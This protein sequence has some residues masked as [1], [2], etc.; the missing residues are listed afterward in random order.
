[1]TNEINKYYKDDIK[2]IKKFLNSRPK[3]SGCYCYG[4]G[5]QFGKKIYSL[6]ILSNDIWKWQTLNSNKYESTQYINF[7]YTTGYRF[8]EYV[9]IKENNCIFDYTIMDEDEFVENQINWKYFTYAE[10]F[11]KPFITI[12]SSKKFD[13]YIF[14]NRKNALTTSLLMFNDN[15]KCFFDIMLN[16]YCI[17]GYLT[18]EKITFVKENYDFLK[19]IYKDYDFININN[20]KK[21]YVNT[22]KLKEEVQ[23][24]PDKIRDNIYEYKGSPRISNVGHFLENKIID[25]KDKISDMRYLVNGFFRTFDYSCRESKTKILKRGR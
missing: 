11:Q 21:I 24:L 5:E 23:F 7:L 15:E 17:S 10:I 25:E 4:I 18:N 3:I 9:G 6:I 1:M 22:D 8:V 19:G 13:Q 2:T 12:K 14:D 20:T 16:L